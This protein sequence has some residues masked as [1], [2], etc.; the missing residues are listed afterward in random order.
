MVNIYILAFRRNDIPMQYRMITCVK[1]LEH[2]NL[3]SPLH[4]KQEI[5]NATRCLKTALY[6]LTFHALVFHL[7]FNYNM[8]NLKNAIHH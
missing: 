4:Q 8:N 5:S 3:G 2:Q 6:S 7:Y 1:N